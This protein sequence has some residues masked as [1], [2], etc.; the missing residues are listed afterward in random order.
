[1][2]P[3]PFSQ[4]E[5]ISVGN[6]HIMYAEGIKSRVGKVFPAAVGEGNGGRLR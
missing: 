3:G 2:H 6:T 1:M 4:V 5:R